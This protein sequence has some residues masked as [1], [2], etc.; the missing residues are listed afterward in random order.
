MRYSRTRGD[1]AGLEERNKIVG[2]EEI[3]Q[4]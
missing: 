3:Q 1:T 4:D 2:P